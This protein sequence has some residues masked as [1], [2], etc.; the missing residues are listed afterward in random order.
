[1]NDP[2]TVVDLFCGAGGFST[3]AALALEELGRTPGEDVEL[4][5]VNHWDVAIE[6]HEA[7]HPWAEHYHSGIEELH[8]PEIAEPGE[9]DL[10]VGGPECTHFSTARGGKPVK[11]QKREPAWNVLTWIQKLQPDHVLLENVKEFR[12]WG[13]I[14]EEGKPTRDGDVFEAW[15]TAIES[16]G[17]AVIRD[18]DG[19]PG[20]VL[21]AADYGDPT[22]RERLFVV[23]SRTD[24]PTAPKP[25]HDEDPGPDDD[26][27]PWRPAADIIDWDD[28]GGSLWT[29]D[30]D[31]QRVQPLSKNTMAR[32]AEGI[33]RHCSDRMEPLAD[34]VEEIGGDRLRELRENV[35]PLEYAGIVSEC[36]EEPFLIR[37]SVSDRDAHSSPYL[38]RQQ[39]GGV[40]AN[41]RSDPLPTV[42]AGGAIG[43]SAPIRRPLI[44]PRN[45]ARRGLHNNPLYRPEDRP[46]HT[47]TA[48]NHDGHL[49]TP[50]LIHYSHGG[51]IRGVDEDPVPTI[52]TERGGAFALSS[53]SVSYLCP[54]YSGRPAQ[55]PRTRDVGRPMMTIPAS[56]SP[57]GLSSPFL[58][59]YYG[60]SD[61]QPVSEPL[62]TVTAKDR[63]A[64]V[65]PDAFPWGLDV[66]Y[67][68]L[69]PGELKQAQGFP[70][71]YHLA[72]DTKR[73]V[74]E[75][76]G[77]AVPVGLAKALCKHAL[78]VQNG[79]LW[80]HGGGIRADPDAEL[81]EY[82]EVVSSDD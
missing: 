80:D 38:L 9:V 31:N 4:H 8:P 48:S 68:M 41:A 18:D 2:I 26:L 45:G 50:S 47:V 19:E 37:C 34:A 55:R 7:N 53:P 69:K 71:D 17:Y 61:A 75:Q 64:L 24:Q 51:S 29:R 79:S 10:L 42:S 30:L 23:A 72:G 46:L 5:A 28:L 27:D 78:G 62:P 63:F 57:A 36:V 3:G 32:I 14:D 20:I 70:E 13:K 35:V 73:E 11:N 49:V 33:R 60:N 65:V 82:Q 77:N 58:V 74:T 66:R 67:R 22:S 43:L 21:N 81:P 76:I 1:M 54:M 52:A 39:S 40:P 59:E 15:V 6:S 44:K 25:T 56:K 12:K 16:L